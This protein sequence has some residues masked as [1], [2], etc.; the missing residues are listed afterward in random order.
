MTKAIRK[1]G[2][3]AICIILLG[4]MIMTMVKASSYSVLV[5]DDFSH[6]NTV[7]VF[8]TSFWN[9]LVASFQYAVKEYL[10]WQGTYF[11]MFIQALLSPINNY[12]M[13]QLRCVMAVN[14]L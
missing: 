14:S 6:G 11:S 8:H 12:G 7:G 5:A 4:W 2:I 9:Y 1:K 10:E 13:R 3:I